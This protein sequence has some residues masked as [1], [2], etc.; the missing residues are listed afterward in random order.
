MGALHRSLLGS[1]AAV[2]V[3]SACGSNHDTLKQKD[4]PPSSGGSAGDAAS[5]S[6]NDAGP[7]AAGDAAKD[8]FVEPVGKSVLTI[9]HGVVDAPRIALCFA[10]VE[11]GIPA[12][13]IGAP[14][15]AAG[16]TWGQPMVLDAIAGFD[17]GVDDIQP[18]VVTGDFSLLSGKS[19]TEALAL[20]ESFADAGTSGGEGG[21]DAAVADA[22]V[23]DASLDGGDAAPMDA[24]TELPP[25]PPVRAL[26]LPALPAGTLSGGYSYLLVPAGCIGGPGFTDPY[27]IFV[28]GQSYTPSTPTL[29]PVLVQ[30]SRVSEPASLGLQFVNAAL[31][32]DPI[33]LSSTAPE[34][35]S[36]PDVTIVY[37][38]VFGAVAP[39]PPL[40]GY[41]K[42]AFGSPFGSAVIEVNS[43]NSSAPFFTST[44]ADALSV[45]GL[46]DVSDGRTYAAILVGPRPNNMELNWWNGPR[47]VLVATDPVA[48]K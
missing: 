37:D 34:G 8:A 38:V 18:I 9:V 11:N 32:S 35:S 40:F 12:A 17:W 3:A 28:C 30:L 48:G 19:C 23:D 20:A 45:G 41:S 6:G 1:A 14:L 31:A 39:R 27:D 24:A 33:D 36:L 29:T 4:P 47:V 42:S 43:L 46:A 5:D 44:W 7:D 22:G 26:E 21:A 2:L 10:K 25:P 13:P 16:L 15:P